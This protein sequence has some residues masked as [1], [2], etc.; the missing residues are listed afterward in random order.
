MKRGYIFLLY[1]ILLLF[2]FFS[3]AALAVPVVRTI[4]GSPLQIKVGDDA[5]FQIFNS[6][7]PGTGQIYPSGSAQT[8]DMGIFVR[9]AGTLFAPDFSGHPSGTATGSLGTT[10][11]WT[12]ISLSAVSG[13]GTTADPFTV[14]V[15]ADAAATGLR[16]TMTVTYVNTENFFRKTLAFSSTSGAQTFDAF[17]GGDIYLAG[18]D[19]GVPYTISGSVGGQTCVPPTYTILYIPLTPADRFSARFY[20]TVWSE[21]G[22]GTLSNI[23]D[24]GCQDNG[25][26]LQWQNRT[27]SATG[28]SVQIQTATSF[29]AIPTIATFRVDTVTANQGQ[30]GQNLP[31]V[32]ITG[33]GFQAGTTFN[34]GSGITVNSTTINSPTQATVALSIAAAATLGFRDV[35]GTQ[36]SGGLTS[37]L[38]NGFEVV[39][40]GGTSFRVDAVTANQ[41]QQGQNLPVVTITG[42]GFQAG[43]TFNFGSGITVNSTTINSPTQATVALSIAA[44]ANL[45]FRNVIGT[46]TSEGLTSTL[47]NGFQVVGSAVPP[48]T[49]Q[50]VPTLSE[51]GLFFAALLLALGAWRSLG[52]KRRV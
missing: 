4:T 48:V 2:S 30:Q 23:I 43:T 14:T 45:G 19:T 26:A 22:T 42:V 41:G 38:T 34:F 37:T 33:V 21:I 47:T 11:P 35:I 46:Q 52:R 3:Q 29:G 25:A 18:A 50:P 31:V 49:V 8:A 12:P 13:T 1:T 5:S 51:W 6:A 15:V 36:T 40:S 27:I 20:S 16:L 7:V 24:S 28:G 10:T 17:L 44:A 9:R 39:G 32:T